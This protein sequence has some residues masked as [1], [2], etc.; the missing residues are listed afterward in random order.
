MYK[1]LQGTGSSVFVLIQT[2]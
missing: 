1:Y 2:W